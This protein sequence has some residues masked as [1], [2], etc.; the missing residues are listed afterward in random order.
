MAVQE[1]LAVL[2]I[3]VGVAL[4]F[5]S[6][7]AST[8][9]DG[10]VRQLSK[11]LV[12][13]MQYQLDA[14]GPEGVSERV[15]GEARSLP[16]VRAALPLLEQ[17]ASVIG[18]AGRASVDLIGAD[19]RFASI[20]GPL[21]RRF[22]TRQLAFQAGDRAARADRRGD[23]RRRPA[24]AA[25]HAGA[26]RLE[27]RCGRRPAGV[28]PRPIELQIGAH[29]VR[30]ILG[31]TLQEA[32]VGALVHS[33]VAL[34]PVAYAQQ[35]GGMTGRVT[36]VFVQV[37]PGRRTE[38]R[39]GLA[40]LAAAWHLNLEPADF[41]AKLFAVASTPAQ[42]SEGLFSVISAIVGF[43]FAFNAMLLTVPERRRMI[44]AMRRRGATR[45]MTVQA[46]MFDA[47]V[48]GVLACVLGL[49]VGEV[50]S[51][52]A[53]HSQPGYLS[54][55]FPVGSQRVVTWPTVALAVGAGLLAA[56][57]GVLAPLRDI[58]ARPLR[59][60][61]AAERAPRGWTRVSRRS[62]GRSAWRSRR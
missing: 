9:L 18:P 36:R 21:L 60:S 25:R 56:F 51:I 54:F 55:A 5:A 17:Q 49:L 30:T 41:D 12:G 45:T 31:I 53:F 14:R 26:R 57:V 40:R 23:R 6:Q 13:A 35:V 3:A 32:D 29:V 62:P 52:E 34:A 7:V 15:A 8:S 11:Q 33:Q 46:L 43:L 47:L 48:I 27:A 24:R 42:Q 4:L 19:P 39:A 59:R 37:R 38:V 50:L 10:S 22:S 20:G 2:G 61:A 28:A 44:E 1:L 58:L 16:G